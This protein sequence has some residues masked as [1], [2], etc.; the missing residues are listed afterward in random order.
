[1]NP[2]FITGTDEWKSLRRTKIT[3]TD[4][5]IILNINPY[6]SPFELWQRKLQLIPEKEQTYAMSE[7]L[8]LEPIARVLLIQVIGMDLTPKVIIHPIYDHLMTSLDGICH[9]NKIICEIKCSQK[10]YNKAKLGIIDPIYIAQ[11]QHHMSV[12]ETTYCE[13][14]AYWEDKYILITIARDEKFIDNMRKK[15]KEFYDNLMSFTPP[16]LSERLD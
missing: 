2:E 8:R 1:M 5:S 12:C 3:S 4:A 16:E 10:I 6:C 7:G 11:C 9:Q 15:E 13:F 14:F